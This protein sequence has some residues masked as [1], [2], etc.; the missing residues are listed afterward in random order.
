MTKTALVVLA[1]GAEELETIATVDIL[2]RGEVKVTL[3]GL[4]GSQPVTCSRNVVIVPDESLDDAIMKGPYDMIV[5]PGG[6][7]GAKANAA[8]GKIKDILQE[9]EQG[10]RYIASICAGPI[11]FGSHKVAQGHQI[12]S[13]PSVKDQLVAE[14]FRYSEARV[15][16]DGRIITSRGPGTSV[17][18]ALALVEAL[19][20][21]EMRDKVGAP[22]VLPPTN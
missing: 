20:G 1:P 12:T 17:E 21:K 11:A 13:H 4:E 5:L 3:A 15:V 8:S 18:F 7:G 9:Q 19:Q 22:M 10:G 6:L 14:G 2:R 16:T